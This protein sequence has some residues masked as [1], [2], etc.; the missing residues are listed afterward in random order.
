MVG[1]PVPKTALQKSFEEFF[2]V[3][4]IGGTPDLYCTGPRDVRS[5]RA[6]DSPEELIVLGWRKK[7]L[8]VNISAQHSMLFYMYT[9]SNFWHSLNVQQISQEC[10]Y[11]EM[12]RKQCFSS[13]FEKITQHLNCQHTLVSVCILGCGTDSHSTTT[14]L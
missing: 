2:V 9:Q 4:K 10:N 8:F 5:C 14:I 3:T 6:W 7:N 13:L 12:E 11:C 1:V